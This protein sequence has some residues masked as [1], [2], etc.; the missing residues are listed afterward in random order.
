M[1]RGSILAF[2]IAAASFALLSPSPTPAQ[3]S[4]NRSAGIA[5]VQAPVPGA[6]QDATQMTPAQVE[7]EHTLDAK[8]LQPGSQFRAKLTDT[9]HLKDGQKLP[10]GTE[11][12]GTVTTD[13]EQAGKRSSANPQAADNLRLALRFTQARLKDGKTLPIVATIVGVSPPE[14]D[15]QQGV[16]SVSTPWDGKTTQV[17]QEGVMSGV[18]LHSRIGGDNSG[19]FVSTRNNVKI[20]ERSRLALALGS[21]NAAQG[22]S[23]SGGY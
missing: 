21:S 14:G 5:Q 23:G 6:P 17:D 3:N 7:L 22:A 19:V 10:H 20:R 1:K 16:A 2:S 8:S 11:L 15:V 18:D 12:I 13:N 9:V 4:G